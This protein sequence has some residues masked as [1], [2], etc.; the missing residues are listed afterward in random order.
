MGNEKKDNKRLFS[1]ELFSDRMEDL[2]RPN[3]KTL[4]T[5]AE[6]SKAIF[7][8]TKV[9]ISATQLG[10]YENA[11]KKEAPNINNLLAIA[12]FYG[13]SLDYLLGFSKATTLIPEDKGISVSIGLSDDAIKQLRNVY[14]RRLRDLLYPSAPYYDIDFFN[15][16][17]SNQNFMLNFSKR[18]LSY[19]NEKMKVDKEGIPFEIAVSDIDSAKYLFTK[20]TEQLADDCYNNFYK[21][22]FIK[23][24]GNKK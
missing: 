8:K 9:S 20:T 19:F 13:V 17:L 15:Y 6:L 1:K 10:K 22:L 7:E 21:P 12:E 14:N 2:R 4:Y 24:R 16:M 5:L 23:E 18:L 3:G 11:D